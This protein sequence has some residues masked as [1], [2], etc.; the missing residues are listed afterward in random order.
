[1]GECHVLQLARFTPALLDGYRAHR[2]KSVTGT[3]LYHETT[4]IKQFAKWALS[5]GLIAQNPIANYGLSKPVRFSKPVPTLTDVSA[6]L[7]HAYARPATLVLLLVATGMRAG[8]LQGL[9]KQD[10]DV[11]AGIIKVRRQI[12]GPTKTKAERRIPIHPLIRPVLLKLLAADNHELLVTNMATHRYP[13]GGRPINTR[14]LLDRF[15]AG[16]ARAG[17]PSFTIHSLRHA[18]NTAALNVGVPLPLVRQSMGHSTRSMT[19]LHYDASDAESLRFMAKMP[20]DG[21][22]AAYDAAKGGL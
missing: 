11:D 16:A 12:H 1:M 21:L 8:E 13:A 14:K 2:K 9:R 6:I 15:Q 7:G 10:I 20:F 19:E 4:V 5:R 3:T 17:L 18:F 22:V